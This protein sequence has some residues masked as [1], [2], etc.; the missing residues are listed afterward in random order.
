M[1]N[2]KGCV[3]I[4]YST[5]DKEIADKVRRHLIDTNCACWMAPYDIPAGSRY[6]HLLN[7][8]LENCSCLLLL[9]SNAAQ[10][11]QFVER[12]VER[13]VTYGKPIITVKLE[14]LVL[15][16]GFK[17]YIGGRQ[18]IDA[19]DLGTNPD[20]LK[21]LS[22]ALK[23]FAAY[24]IQTKE[25]S[26]RI[27]ITEDRAV[28]T[29]KAKQDK[30]ISP[31]DDLIEEGENE[32]LCRR[33][34][35]AREIFRRLVALGEPIGYVKLANS[36]RGKLS[37]GKEAERTALCKKART[38]FE[39][40]IKKGQLRY[41]YWLACISGRNYRAQF[42]YGLKDKDSKEYLNLMLK[43]AQAGDPAA[44]YHAAMVYYP[45]LNQASD[46][47]Y[48]LRKAAGQEYLD[49]MIRLAYCYRR[50][51]GTEINFT[52]A[53]YWE[54]KSFE[55]SLLRY[56]EKRTVMRT[57]TLA[58]AFKLGRG[59]PKNIERAAALYKEAADMGSLNAQFQLGVIYWEEG[60]CAK[61]VKM[62][63]VPAENMDYMNKTNCQT[64]R[65]LLGKM[66]EEGPTGVKRDLS[67]AGKYYLMITEDP[68]VSCFLPGGVYFSAQEALKRLRNKSE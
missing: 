25:K 15:N 1:A 34:D 55:K 17:F 37:T 62:L 65:A 63:T 49:A 18:I 67:K 56:N 52:Q 20:T 47:L 33:D 9:L 28:L 22:D 44:Q 7:D 54:K 38:E 5:S 46:Y 30:W 58:A 32:F 16:S 60:D 61:A 68:A 27:G 11:S 8:A 2:G 29:S 19:F 36:Y 31:Y 35:K 40:K 66:Y 23:S 24:T 51:Y 48:W 43:G 53:E 10:E 21:M 6:A 39:S 26:A 45:G 64:A 12:E 57:M 4:S 59:C 13:A 41:Y 3:F 42:T 50:G 14:D